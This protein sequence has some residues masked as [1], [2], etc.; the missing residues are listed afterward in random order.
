MTKYQIIEYGATVD[1]YEI[2][3]DS[4]EA[5]EKEFYNEKATLINSYGESDFLEVSE[6]K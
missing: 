1:T 2:E 3:A 5:A 4:E 6:A